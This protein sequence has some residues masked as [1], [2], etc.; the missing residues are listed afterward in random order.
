MSVLYGHRPK[1]EELW[2]LSPHEFVIHSLEGYDHFSIFKPDR[3]KDASKFPVWNL[4][5]EDLKARL[6]SRERARA[7]TEASTNIR[8]IV[9]FIDSPFSTKADYEAWKQMPCAEREAALSYALQ[10]VCIDCD[11]LVCVSRATVL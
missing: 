10:K 11:G 4:I 3:P 5:F 1:H 6:A 2:H 9:S 7:S 8:P